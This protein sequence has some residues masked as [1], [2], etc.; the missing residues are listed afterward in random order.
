[1]R[2]SCLGDRWDSS[3]GGCVQSTGSV[4]RRSWP[5]TCNRE[6]WQP[7]SLNRLI[8]SPVGSARCWPWHEL[9]LISLKWAMNGLLLC[10]SVPSV[11]LAQVGCCMATI[12]VDAWDSDGLVDLWCHGPRARRVIGRAVGSANR[13]MLCRSI[14]GL[15][16]TGSSSCLAL[17]GAGSEPALA[18]EPTSPSTLESDGNSS[19]GGLLLVF[20]PSFF[21]SHLADSSPGF[22][23]STSCTGVL[24]GLLPGIKYCVDGC[25]DGVGAMLGYQKVV[26][27]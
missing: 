3:I 20:S 1:M 25:P 14:H 23:Q 21:Y 10:C 27:R 5:A 17:S 19:R 8:A 15:F 2:L 12:Y 7:G 18:R 24:A 9:R 4:D 13:V 6:T 11:L 16:G 26:G 22:C